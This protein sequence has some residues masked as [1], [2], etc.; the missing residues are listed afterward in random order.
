[1]K[2]KQYSSAGPVP[3]LPLISPVLH[4]V[5]MTGLVFLRSSFGYS[6]LSPK[7][8]FLACIWALALFSFYAWHE[9]GAWPHWR[10]AVLYGI[11]TSALYIG[12]LLKAFGREV[13][14][15]GKHDYFAGESHV[16]KLA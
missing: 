4:V 7:S 14:R 2:D 15:R 13:G 11:L 9:P 16:L 8:I 6:F 3:G 12:H 10:A 5:S 1:M